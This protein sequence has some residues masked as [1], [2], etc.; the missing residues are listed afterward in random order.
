[1]SWLRLAPSLPGA[2]P[3]LFGADSMVGVRSRGA[4]AGARSSRSSPRPY[5]DGGRGGSCS[6]RRRTS[7]PY[8]TNRNTLPVVG[9]ERAA[10][11]HS[12]RDDVPAHQH[13]AIGPPRSGR[14]RYGSTVA[15]CRGE[16]AGAPPARGLAAFGGS[17]RMRHERRLCTSGC[18]RFTGRERREGI[19]DR[20]VIV[21][22]RVRPRGR[23]GGVFRLTA[24]ST[25]LDL[26]RLRV[27]T[28]SVSAGRAGRARGLLTR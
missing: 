3:P 17:A 14:W 16:R 10:G 21:L 12:D 1:V 18:A 25:D 9:F 20:G 15:S 4:A 7:W 6:G 5:T 26:H 19:T 28:W 23:H 13:A 11:Q 8:R 22:P 27:T 24:R 2:G